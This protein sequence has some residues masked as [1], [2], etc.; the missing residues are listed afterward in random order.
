[1]IW[2]LPHAA[3]TCVAVLQGTMTAVLGEDGAGAAGKGAW[4]CAATKSA[5]EA[6][7]SGNRGA[8]RLPGWPEPPYL[9][10][11]VMYRLHASVAPQSILL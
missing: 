4:A 10:R 8:F 2:G 7:P 3:E 9:R 11:K 1:M 5:P 6:N